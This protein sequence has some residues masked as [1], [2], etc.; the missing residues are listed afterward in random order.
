MTVRAKIDSEITR[1][2][3][4]WF[5]VRELQEKLRV[6]NSTLKPLI[7]RYARDSVLVRRKV[8]GVA[9]AVQFSPAAKNTKEFQALLDKYMPYKA[10]GSKI[11]T[12]SSKISAKKT[13]AKNTEKKTENNTAKKSSSKKTTSKK[14]SPAKRK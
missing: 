9:R 5:T 2:V 12:V 13:P 7:M 14:N 1:R 11:M 8:K 6:E 4:K 10:K 3:G